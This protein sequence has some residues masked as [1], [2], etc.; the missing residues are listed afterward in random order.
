MVDRWRCWYR[1][2]GENFSAEDS[3]TGARGRMGGCRDVVEDVDHRAGSPIENRRRKHTAWPRRKL[4]FVLTRRRPRA[5]RGA[6]EAG[7]RGK[8]LQQSVAF[9]LGCGRD[10]LVRWRFFDRGDRVQHRLFVLLRGPRLGI[11]VDAER[12]RVFQGGAVDEIFG[13]IACCDCRF[14]RLYTVETVRDVGESVLIWGHGED[15][16]FRVSS[17]SR[18]P[19]ADG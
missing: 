9:G 5:Y 4:V 2:G 6:L 8:R 14:C 12:M 10:L 1:L 11:E 3:R 13:R 19:D 15:K 17:H 18:G 16:V 7:R